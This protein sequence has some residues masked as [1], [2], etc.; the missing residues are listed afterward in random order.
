MT[1][2]RLREQAGTIF[3]AFMIFFY[4]GV[5]FYLILSKNL[6]Y[7]DKFLRFIVGATFILIGISRAYRTYQ[8]VVEVFFTDEDNN[9]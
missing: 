1:G 6:S 7:M 3:G 8:K 4:L 5:G 9:K 2:N